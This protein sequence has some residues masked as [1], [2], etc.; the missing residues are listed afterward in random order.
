VFNHGVWNRGDRG[1]E[2]TSPSGL[3][4]RSRRKV[5]ARTFALWVAILC[6]PMVLFAGEAGQCA[7]TAHS[8]ISWTAD[9]ALQSQTLQFDRFPSELLH[10]YAK[11]DDSEVNSLATEY[12]NLAAK[13][14]CHWDYGDAVHEA[15]RYLGRVSLR[16]GNIAAADEFLLRAGKS[17]GSP[18]LDSFGPNLD[19]ANRLLQ[20]GEV[21]P[22]EQYLTDVAVFWQPGRKQIDL[23]LSAIRAGQKPYL[24]ALVAHSSWTRVGAVALVGLL[25]LIPEGMVLIVLLIVR[26][27]LRRKLAFFF[28]ASVVANVIVWSLARVHSVSS[29]AMIL[30]LPVLAV[31]VL[32]RFWRR[33]FGMPGNAST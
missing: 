4:P 12:L 2:V 31:Y 16:N 24:N 21:I 5:K 1:G 33:K 9:P 32:Y 18:V 17:P 7:K 15:N 26:K 30:P 6:V 20:R 28:A 29:R 22:V 23:W 11:G 25:L 27:R 19:L 13:Y 8:Q 3:G 10:A 14:P